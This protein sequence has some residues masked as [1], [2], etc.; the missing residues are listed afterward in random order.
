LQ[1]P[2]VVSNSSEEP[3]SPTTLTNELGGSPPSKRLCLRSP[4]HKETPELTRPRPRISA[5]LSR[6]SVKR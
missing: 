3:K 6:G 5:R 2:N 4:E 1:K